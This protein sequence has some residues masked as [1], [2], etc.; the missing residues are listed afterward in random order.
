[1]D[2]P[3]E[4]LSREL[5]LLRAQLAGV[6]ARVSELESR[7][8]RSARSEAAAKPEVEAKFPPLTDRPTP[9]APP[10]LASAGA[11]EGSSSGASTGDPFGSPPR[12][13]PTPTAPHSSLAQINRLPSKPQD[14]LEQKIGQYWLN[15]IGIV[16]VLTGIS[17]FLKYAFENNWI[18]PSGR[19]GIG[20][21][22]GIALILWSE[23][24]RA[25][26]HAPF[27]YSLKA[28]GLGALYLSLWA[29]FQVYRLIPAEVAF[30][31]MVAVTAAAIVLA[32]TQD[33][34][35]LAGFALAG[36]YATPLLLST[37]QNHEAELFTY[38][39][40]LDIAVLA[41]VIL[42]PWLKLAW[43]SF[44]GTEIL[45]VAWSMSYYREAYRGE[46]VTFLTL[47]AVTF[48][49]GP[50]LAKNDEDDAGRQLSVASVL[51]VLNVGAYFGALFAMYDAPRDALTWYA[52]AIAAV[53]L[54]LAEAFRRLH[55]EETTGTIRLVHL[56]LAVT[57]L[58]IAVPL[59]LDGH[60]IAV[61][62]I[63]E[64]GALL[65]I[66]GRT[67][68]RL[69][70]RLGIAALVLGILR[71]LIFSWEHTP[72]LFFN[73]RFMT[74]ALAIALL[75]AI[76]RYG[77]PIASENVRPFLSMAKIALSLLALTALTLEAS[78]FFDRQITHTQAL[79]RNA[80]AFSYLQWRVLRDFTYS[81]IWLLYGASLMAVGFWKRS[82]FVR[83]QALVLIAFTVGKVF[84]YD[85]SALDKGYR[86][87]SF[88]ALGGVLLA[89]SFVYQRDWLSLSHTE[90][91]RKV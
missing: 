14:D 18:G 49:L 87:V 57:F 28:L 41:L 66:A 53:Y 24:F 62:W 58:T 30:A 6:S 4:E 84:L 23:R 7:A 82:A 76:I 71:L 70:G 38:V 36:G 29:A 65:W 51:A 16:A 20:L 11:P 33:A 3:P 88:V 89:V 61:G 77:E 31:A 2:K 40:L 17:Y 55:P 81:A 26:G 68:A 34:M 59:K 12:V 60:W 37:G 69:L 72:R 15:R 39:M 47:F 43:G 83:W 74:Y 46:T 21:L 67:G 52:L 19:V 78:D 85:V 50:L 80:E 27:S 90:E 73:E 56:T 91:A 32:W 13:R 79:S 42:K 25:K 63:V 10:T 22:S 9:T 48:A 8:G 45:V 54:G 1:M 86:I 64:S 5:E 75:A 35:V 44:A